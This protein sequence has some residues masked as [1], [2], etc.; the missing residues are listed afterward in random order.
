MA[1]QRETDEKQRRV[2]E[3]L[4]RGGYDALLL[5]RLENFSW[6]TCG[7]D[8]HVNIAQE[9]GVAA[10]LVR[11]DRK[12]LITNA[13]ERARML[14]E[15]VSN[16]GFEEEISPW[17]DDALS[18]VLARV[19]PGE[20][21]AADVAL[22][23]VVACPSDIAQ[24]RQSLTPEEVERLRQLGSDVGA[25][26]GE[27]ATML[28]RGMTEHDAAAAIASQ[29]LCRGVTPIVVLVAADERLL[30]YRHP[31]PTGN[32]IDRTVML[33]VCGRR[34][35]LIVS[36]TRIVHFGA[37]S[38]ELRARHDAVVNVDAAFIAGSRV[39]MRIGDIFKTGLDTYA[40]HGFPEE[41]KLHHQGGPAGYVARE[42]RATADIDDRVVSNQVFAWNPS[43][44]GTKSEDTIVATPEGPEIVSLSP[45]F[46]TL[47]VKVGDLVLP[48]SDILSR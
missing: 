17:T 27:A 47:D 5:A 2:N 34:H 43:I 44:T 38:S 19:A 30:K 29:H 6:F 1:A 32:T 45:G 21:I 36:A 20:K 35:G 41:W 22:S 42:Y 4:E 12:T 3:F 23:G 14:E 8:C 25:A 18:Q 26:I 16:Q 31:L 39:G 37:I 9:T 28:E 33:V 15:E 48:R 40:A 7:G 46:P 10:V 24:L 11:R 13:V